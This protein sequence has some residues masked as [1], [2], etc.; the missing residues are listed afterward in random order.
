MIESPMNN[1]ATRTGPAAELRQAAATLLVGF[2]P[3]VDPDTTMTNSP[4]RVAR[5][6]RGEADR[7]VPA[8]TALAYARAVNTAHPVVPEVTEREMELLRAVAAGGSYKQL[9]TRWGITPAG[10]KAAGGRLLKRLGARSMA[11]AVDIAWRAG[12]LGGRR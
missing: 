1:D 5:W 9:A 6:L 10:A 7:P 8:G 3:N 4:H 12:L 2:D 11:H